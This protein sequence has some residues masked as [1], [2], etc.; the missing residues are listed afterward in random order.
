MLDMKWYGW[1]VTALGGCIAWIGVAMVINSINAGKDGVLIASFG[2]WVTI[3][4]L[5]IFIP[6]IRRIIRK[7]QADSSISNG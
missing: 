3:V 2:G 4:T 5:C 6:I 1:L 7:G